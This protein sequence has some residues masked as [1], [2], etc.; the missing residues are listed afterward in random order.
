M[1]LLSKSDLNRIVGQAYKSTRIAKAMT[2]ATSLEQSTGT[3]KYDIFLSHSYL[4]KETV[5]QINY[6]LEDTFGFRVFVDWIE[7]PELDRSKVTPGTAAEMRSVMDRCDTLLY[8][9]STKSSSSTWMPWELGYSDAKHGRIAVLPISDYKT[10]TST[11]KGQEF[12][13]LYPYILLNPK[14]DD[15]SGDQFLWV[16]DPQDWNKYSLF[17]Y[18]RVFGTLYDHA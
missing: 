17:N 3:E 15:D 9:I 14:A 4:D 6:L 8:T 11:Y 13:G 16:H 1:P 18:W 2:D 12:V 5:L 10:T 7:K